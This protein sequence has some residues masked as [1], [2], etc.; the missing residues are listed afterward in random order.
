MP[1]CDAQAAGYLTVPL[2]QYVKSAGLLLPPEEIACAH[3][4]AFLIGDCA[5][6]IPVVLGHGVTVPHV[7]NNLQSAEILFNR[8]PG[9]GCAKHRAARQAV[10]SA[11]DCAHDQMLLEKACKASSG[12]E[13]EADI[14][15]D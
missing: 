3:A 1:I 8:W 12:T 10:P 2:L 9:K 5:M 7:N 13:K 6:W 15:F 11:M 14:L 4:A